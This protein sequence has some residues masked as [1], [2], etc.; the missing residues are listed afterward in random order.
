MA[1]NKKPR[2][3]Y[4]PKPVNP[5]AFASAIIGTQPLCEDQQESLGAAYRCAFQGLRLGAGTEE[6]FNT[7]ACALNIA[8]VLCESGCGA[9]FV[10][11]VKAA[12]DGLMRCKERGENLGKWALDGEAIVSLEAALAVHDA[13]MEAATQREIRE[14]IAEVRRR[15]EVG[16]VLELT[17]RPG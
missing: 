17:E 14:A 1:N 6:L 9:E 10:G 5:G 2:R 13:Q 12:Q 8:M 7:L 11:R 4:R 3:K 16:E 15:V